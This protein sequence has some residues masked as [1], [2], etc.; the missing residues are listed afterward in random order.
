MPL[1]VCRAA[2][3]LRAVGLIEEES[4]PISSILDAS[5][6]APDALKTSWRRVES[7]SG[8]LEAAMLARLTVLAITA[9][10]LSMA[11]LVEGPWPGGIPGSTTPAAAQDRSGSGAYRAIDR[12]S[13]GW[14]IWRRGSGLL[15]GS[16][17]FRNANSYPIWNVIVACDFFDQ[18]GNPIGT[19]ATAV[20]RI[21]GPGRARVGGIYFAVAR[22]DTEGG[23]CRVISAAPYPRASVPTS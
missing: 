13:V 5:P 1:P 8:N 22:P 3:G 6:A 19:R 11:S 10:A 15:Y 9:V 12:V 21:F 23:A 18:W 4:G 2:K 17:T 7:G 20:D 14:P 16:M